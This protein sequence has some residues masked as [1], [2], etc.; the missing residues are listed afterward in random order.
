MN[1]FCLKLWNW[2]LTYDCDYGID[3]RFGWSIVIDGSVA[4]ELEPNLFRAACVA[5]QKVWQWE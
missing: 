5:I 1:V 3:H 2:K 4:A